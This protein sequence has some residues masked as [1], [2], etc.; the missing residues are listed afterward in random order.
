M[1]KKNLIYFKLFSVAFFFGGTF[2]A[3]K[4]L[5]QIVPPF[6][7]A[8]LRFFIASIFLIIFVVKKHGKLPRLNCKQFL[9]ILILGFSGIMGYNFFFFSGL[10][11]I[12]ASRASMIISCNPVIIA[13]F[14]SLLFNE[15]FTKYKLTGIL[16]S[17]IGALI[18]IS[19]GNPLIILQGNIGLGE[20][21]I[22]GCVGCWVIFTLTGKIAMN[23]LP[24]LIVITYAC[25]IGSIILLIPGY[26]EGELHHLIRFNLTKWLSVLFLGFFGTALSF[27]WYYEG[28]NKIGPSKSGIFLNFVPVCAVIL[29]III[30]NE[31]LTF[32]LVLGAI[33]VVSGIY[34]TNK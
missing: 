34:L 32:S 2:I 21:Y 5:S 18:V 28:I 12:S 20:L 33:L 19:R 1:I 25:I 17:L 23:K 22:L 9:T 4:I 26:F 11:I 13:G 16:I 8:F 6:T 7:S 3:G 15:K 31:P 29:A 24:P 14:S 27:N 10:K 30:L